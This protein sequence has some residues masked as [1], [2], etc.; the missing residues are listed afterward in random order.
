[1]RRKDDGGERTIIAPKFQQDLSKSIL[2]NLGN[3]LTNLFT[4]SETHYYQLLIPAPHAGMTQNGSDVPRGISSLPANSLPT[5]ISPHTNAAAA[6]G[7]PFRIRIGSIN[8][9][10]AIAHLTLALS[11]LLTDGAR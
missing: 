3:F 7:S 5:S 9:V 10:I 2:D 4:P 11:L 6:P 1:M 8:L